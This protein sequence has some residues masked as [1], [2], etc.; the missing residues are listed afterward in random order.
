MARFRDIAVKLQSTTALSGLLRMA[1]RPTTNAFSTF[2][3][4]GDQNVLATK[5]RI[6]Y[7]EATIRTIASATLEKYYEK[8]PL[9]LV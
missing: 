9:R 4:L 7:D 8:K 6:L 1:L 2:I 3:A 5:T